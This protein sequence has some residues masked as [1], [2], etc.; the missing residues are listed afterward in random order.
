MHVN[1][2]QSKRKSYGKLVTILN[3]TEYEEND[4]WHC[5][6]QLNLCF[7]DAYIKK[8]KYLKSIMYAYTVVCEDSTCGRATKPIHHNYWAHAPQ[9][10]KLPQWEGHTTQLGSSPHSPELES[11]CATTKIQNTQK[12]IY[13]RYADSKYT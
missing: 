6:I 3:W 11:P 9:Q 10:E 2:P 5:R 13:K 4:L 7:R 12:W 8:Q 1:N